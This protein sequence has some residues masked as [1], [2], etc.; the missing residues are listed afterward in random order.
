MRERLLIMLVYAIAIAAL[1]KA[2]HLSAFTWGMLLVALAVGTLRRLNPVWRFAAEVA[3]VAVMVLTRQTA[4]PITVVVT[5]AVVALTVARSPHPSADRAVLGGLSITTIAALV[6]RQA[7]FAYLPLALVAVAALVQGGEHHLESTAARMRLAATIAVVA[8][9]GATLVALLLRLLPWQRALALL[10][11][12][13]AYPFL[14]L[15]SQIHVNPS[16]RRNPNSVAPHGLGHP[17]PTVA[18]HVPTGLTIVF[19][20][21]GV[22]LLA[23]ILYVAYQ[24]WAHNDVIEATPEEA[25]IIREALS[26]DGGLLFRRRRT[27]GLSPVRRFVERRLWAAARH[28]RARHPDETLREWMQHQ[29]PGQG[30][31]ALDTYEAIRYGDAPD[32]VDKEREIR[33]IWPHN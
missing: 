16:A 19:I 30:G 6:Q 7:A 22:A 12:I 20:I 15:A 21:V 14:L 17:P 29:Y 28:Q 26:D 23:L 5:A 3:V 24:Y 27:A 32:T 11:T 1:A 2:L 13:V 33:Q 9:A 4:L 31:Q 8:A 25:G 10:F 18:T